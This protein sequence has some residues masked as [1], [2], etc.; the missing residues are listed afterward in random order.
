MTCP[1][2]GP[3]TRGILFLQYI[4]NEF[5]FIVHIASPVLGLLRIPRRPPFRDDDDDDESAAAGTVGEH[6]RFLLLPLLSLSLLPRRS[7]SA[8]S[9]VALAELWVLSLLLLASVVLS[10]L[11]WLSLLTVAVS[12]E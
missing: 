10:L 12:A 7:T 4:L 5:Q 11:L 8:I 1:R 9:V 6:P 3:G 2:C